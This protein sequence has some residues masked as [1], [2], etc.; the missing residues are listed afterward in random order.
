MCRLEN[1][2]K[3]I[4]ECCPG[5]PKLANYEFHEIDV[6]WEE[7]DY[8]YTISIPMSEE[9]DEVHILN[10]LNE[11]VRI[12]KIKY[13][14][15]RNYFE[16]KL[17]LKRNNVLN[18]KLSKII[19]TFVDYLFALEIE[20]NINFTFNCNEITI[21]LFE[22]KFKVTITLPGRVLITKTEKKFKKIDR[23]A[24]SKLLRRFQKFFRMYDMNFLIC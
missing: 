8:T 2:Q 6:F 13:S 4:S 9:E 15:L 20:E 1:V 11:K 19:H 3:L 5:Q 17:L 21:N 12:Y 10:F 14:Q 18:G 7:E 22:N 23:R 16:T 24:T